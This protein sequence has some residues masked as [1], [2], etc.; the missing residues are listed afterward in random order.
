MCLDVRGQREFG[1]G[2]VE[3]VGSLR[4]MRDGLDWGSA[5]CVV[6]WSGGVGA[7]RWGKALCL[8]GLPPLMRQSCDR[9]TGLRE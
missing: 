5:G 1:I 8:S 4:C 7:Q 3:G 6:G 2:G 9:Q